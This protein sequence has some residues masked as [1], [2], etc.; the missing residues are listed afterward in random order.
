LDKKYTLL[1]E[2]SE[3]G[4]NPTNGMQG[5]VLMANPIHIKLGLMMIWGVQINLVGEISLNRVTKQGFLVFL[6]FVMI[7]PS[8]N[9]KV[10]LI[11]T[12]YSIYIE[13]CGLDNSS[14]VTF[15]QKL[16]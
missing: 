8:Q 13:L 3:L 5:S 12:Y 4:L 16:F 10:W 6:L 14:R 9:S 1:K 15:P 2:F 7:F 11:L